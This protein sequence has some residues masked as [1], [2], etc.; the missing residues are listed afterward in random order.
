[1][2]DLLYKY[3]GWFIAIIALIAYFGGA[4]TWHCL[5]LQ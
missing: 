1:M 4:A 5:G 2:D 3:R